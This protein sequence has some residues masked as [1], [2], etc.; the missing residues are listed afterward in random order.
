MSTGCEG[1][2]ALGS[3]LMLKSPSADLCRLQ[4]RRIT[5]VYSVR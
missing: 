1:I 2:I 4:G 3:L 5:T